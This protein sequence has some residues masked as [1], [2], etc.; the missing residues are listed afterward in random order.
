M[1][2]SGVRIFREALVIK[3]QRAH[4]HSRTAFNRFLELVRDADWAHLN[5]IKMTFNTV[6]YKAPYTI[7]DVGG[8]KYRLIAVV[9]FETG[10]FVI[11]D[12]LTHEQ[13]SRKVF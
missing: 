12:V 8:N 5:E 11:C 9:E 1:G 7:F 10:R 13:Y 4:P 3:F 6:D 2:T